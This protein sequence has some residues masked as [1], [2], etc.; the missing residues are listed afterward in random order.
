VTFSQ[1]FQLGGWANG[2]GRSAAFAALAAVAYPFWS[3]LADPV[4]G[5]GAGLAPYLVGV[6]T[7]WVAGCGP[8]PGVGLLAGAFAGGLGLAL[9]VV[10]QRPGEVAV[11]C[12]LIL[13]VGRSGIVW[14]SGLH[15]GLWRE[16]VFLTA[17]ALLAKFLLLPGPMGAAFALWGFLL[18]QSCWFLL[19]APAPARAEAAPG[20]DGFEQARA[21]ALAILED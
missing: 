19:P 10:A 14:K 13:A 16:V 7:L 17:G 3:V 2:F 11:G 18:V 21:R 20:I 6:T 15:R 4:L 1:S 12:A 8:R 9:L 5:A